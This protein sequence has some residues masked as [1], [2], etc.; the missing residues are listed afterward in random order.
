MSTIWLVIWFA[1]ALGWGMKC[2]RK[3]RQLGRRRRK[4]F[5]SMSADLVACEVRSYV[6]LVSETRAALGA[7]ASLRYQELT[8]KCVE[9]PTRGHSDLVVRGSSLRHSRHDQET[10]RPSRRPHL[11]PF[12]QL[13]PS[14]MTKVH[15]EKPN[16]SHLIISCVLV[17]GYLEIAERVKVGLRL[18]TATA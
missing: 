15:Y 6:I 11:H 18:L 5:V 10:S 1:T 3:L 4:Y 14:Q 12:L 16:N 7:L 2:L 13:N 9:N 8:K 17:S